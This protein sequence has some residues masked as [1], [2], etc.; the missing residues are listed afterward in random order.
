M[1][2][3]ALAMF[4]LNIGVASDRVNNVRV[5]NVNSFRTLIGETAGLNEEFANGT[6]YVT[7]RR[8]EYGHLQEQIEKYL[9]DPRER[10]AIKH[11]GYARTIAQYTYENRVDTLLYKIDDHKRNTT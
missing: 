3:W 2:S 10:E 7:Y 6:E 9:A 5:S 8:S 1:V 11:A 4:M